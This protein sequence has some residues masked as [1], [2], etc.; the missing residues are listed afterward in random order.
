VPVGSPATEPSGP[1]PKLDPPD[2]TKPSPAQLL[3]GPRGRTV[4]NIAASGPSD[5]AAGRPQQRPRATTRLM[6]D[7]FVCASGGPDYCDIFGG[8]KPPASVTV[9]IYSSVKFR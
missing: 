5:R 1:G 3:T 2:H 9:E 6:R 4:A 8:S 7:M